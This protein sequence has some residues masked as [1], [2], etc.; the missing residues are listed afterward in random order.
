[1]AAKRKRTKIVR[2]KKIIQESPKENKMQSIS[3]GKLALGTFIV[4]VILGAFILK[5]N[6]SRKADQGIMPKPVTVSPSPASSPAFTKDYLTPT[7]MVKKLPFTKSEQFQYAIRQGDSLAK[8]GKIFCGN[9]KAYLYL[10]ELNNISRSIPLQPGD[11]IL[12][13]CK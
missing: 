6:N 11:T 7:P 1:M 12:V 9:N 8:I 13:D 4:I 5:T 3:L 10:E 2:S